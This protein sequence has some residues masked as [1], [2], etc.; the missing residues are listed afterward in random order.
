MT[1][2]LPRRRFLIKTLFLSAYRKKDGA[3]HME[4]LHELLIVKHVDS[5]SNMMRIPSVLGRDILNK[6]RL[7]YDRRKGQ[8]TIAN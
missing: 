5:E 4:K 8:V 7:I 1:P 6:Y 2:E 3:V